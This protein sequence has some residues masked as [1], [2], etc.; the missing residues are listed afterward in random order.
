MANQD[1]I[2]EFIALP[3]EQQMSTL[4]Q[5]S[6]EKQDKLLGQIKVRKG[7]PS[8]QDFTANPKGEG[9]YRMSQ[10]A[11]GGWGEVPEVNVP[12][13]NVQSALSAGYRIHPDETARY[14]K[15]VAHPGQGPTFLEKA[16]A[17]IERGLEPNPNEAPQSLVAS[18]AM[19][20][21]KDKAALRVLYNTPGMVKDLYSA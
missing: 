13:G 1:P 14:Q 20:S 3:R 19:L 7:K 11:P 15:D 18:P 5:L 9:T 17:A 12:Y 8:T 21:N 6:P 10:A 2:D 16:K 4:Q